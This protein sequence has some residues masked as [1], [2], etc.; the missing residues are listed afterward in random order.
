[1]TTIEAPIPTILFEDTGDV[2]EFI[3]H[4]YER[5][6]VGKAFCGIPYTQDEHCGMHG[7]ANWQVTKRE[8]ALA[9][10]RRAKQLLR[11]RGW[12]QGTYY[13]L[14]GRDTYCAIGAYITAMNELE[15]VSVEDDPDEA[16]SYLER[17]NYIAEA[18]GTE[19]EVRDET[20]HV[21]VVFFNDAPNRT[22]DEV[23]AYFDKRIAKLE[24]ANG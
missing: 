9:G 24:G 1:M 7:D 22:R 2:D 8:Q 19:L 21:N 6:G 15:V 4:L 18:F 13:G 3:C 23:I 11:Q 12:T 16:Y 17:R 10:L 5:T 20:G 14:D